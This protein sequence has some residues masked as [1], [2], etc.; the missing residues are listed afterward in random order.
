MNVVAAAGAA[1][2]FAAGAAWAAAPSP[3][4]LLRPPGAGQPTDFMARCIRCG[5]CLEACP[6]QA[7]H[8]APLNAGREASTPYVNART[9][10]CRLC[11]DFP[12]AAACPTGAL[13]VPSE[14]T[15]A[16]M[17]VAR[18]NEETCL[19]F[20]GMRC[21]VCYRACPLIDEAIRIDYRPR[22]GDDIHAVFAPSVI[23]DSC[24]GCGLC[25]QRCPVGDPA[26]AIVVVPAGADEDAYVALREG[27]G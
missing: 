20:Q 23:D 11:Q 15:A 5:R 10:A 9:Q 17:G 16:G 18:I 21:E 2:V 3:V 19:S 8:A 6:Y 13:A 4:P 27:A 12:C 7:V 26:P 22:E 24:V 1:L 25:E 14:R